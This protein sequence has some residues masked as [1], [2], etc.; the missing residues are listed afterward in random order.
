MLTGGFTIAGRTASGF[1]AQSRV[2]FGPHETNLCVGRAISS[3]HVDYYAARARGGAGVIVTEAASVH[4]GDWPYERAP[5]AS[6]CAG[7]WR[8]IADACQPHGTLVLAGL[9][10]TG[11][12]G[13]SAFSQSALWGPASVPDPA[14]RELP[15]VMG[16][17]EIAELVAGF[18]AAARLARES[19]LDGVEIDAGPRSLLRQFLSDLTNPAP[20]LEVLLEVLAAVRAEFPGGI[21]ALRLTCDELASWGGITPGSAAADVAAVAPLIDV[22]TIVRGGLMSVDDYRPGMSA[23]PG[24]NRE[25]CLRMRDAAHAVSADVAVVLQGSVVD[26]AMASDALRE[27][28]ADLVEMT[29]AQIAEPDLVEVLRG[30][31]REPR[32]CLLCNQGCLVRDARNPLVDCVV[33]PRVLPGSVMAAAVGRPRAALV[34]G[35]GVAGLEAARVLAE[36][37]V[38]VTMLER[39]DRAGGMLATAAV[40][41][42]RLAL[43]PEWLLA[44]CLELGVRVECGID[45]AV[46][47]AREFDGPVIWAI[48][49]TA[50]PLDFPCDRALTAAEVLDGGVLDGRVLD[51]VDLAGD[52]VAEGPMTVRLMFAG[53]TVGPMIAGPVLVNDPIGGPEGVAVA[54]W[55]RAR[56]HEVAIVTPDP[57]VGVGL[58]RAGDLVGANERVQRAGIGRHV[59]SELVS[60]GGGVAVIEDRHTKG[61]I[62]VDCAV[63]V[64]C[65]P[66]LPLEIPEVRAGWISVGDCVA[67]RTALEAVR[68]GRQAAQSVLGVLA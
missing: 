50:R 57:I 18:A 21:L 12:Q 5:L 61:R 60:V 14:T 41:R 56:G 20:S 33:N 51:G 49:S 31:R 52:P 17:K 36:G 45:D 67:P 27:G 68:E 6:E 11:L 64:D 54:E 59:Y 29:R 3:A 38:E 47:R 66:G 9:G 37:G 34:V 4:P 13:L 53:P 44:R 2:L 16:P 7:G 30:G 42:P 65:S 24:F 15:M 58:A 39:A 48:G 25:L 46:D 1:S 22:L 40:A 26:P 55:L 8:A 23:E 43:L 28:V 19:G 10:H 32:P 62:S 35:A 63:V